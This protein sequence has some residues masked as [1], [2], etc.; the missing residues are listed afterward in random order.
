MQLETVSYSNV[1]FKQPI[2]KFI[3]GVL[4]YER[5]LKGFDF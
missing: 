1:S 5:F 2:A 3:S 4:K